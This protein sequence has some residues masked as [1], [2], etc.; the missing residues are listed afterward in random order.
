MANV[1]I[2]EKDVM[3]SLIAVCKANGEISPRA[4]VI[5][6]VQQPRTLNRK[7]KIALVVTSNNESLIDALIKETLT[8]DLEFS[9]IGSEVNLQGDLEVDYLMFEANIFAKIN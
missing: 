8:N 4:L 2:T 9:F 6:R 3:D 7:V 1:V 5:N